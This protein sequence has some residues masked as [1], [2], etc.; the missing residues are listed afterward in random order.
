MK[1]FSPWRVLRQFTAESAC[2]TYSLANAVAE[3]K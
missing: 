3:E 2:L 1:D